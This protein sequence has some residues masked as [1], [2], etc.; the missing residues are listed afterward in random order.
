[1]TIIGCD[2]HPG[3]Q[4]I[5][6]VDTDTGDCGERRLQH[7][8]EAEK[9]Y[10]PIPLLERYGHLRR[11]GASRVAPGP[12]CLHAVAN[13]PAGP[14][15]LNRSLLL[16]RRRPSPGYGRVGSCITVF[17]AC[18]AFTRVT[19]CRLAESPMRPSTPEASAASLPPPPL[20][21]LPGGA[22]QFPGGSTSR[23]GSVPLHGA[24]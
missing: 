19:A 13:A 12:L 15:R 18:S 6:F 3:F 20:R 11:E 22:I 7:V 14:R 8:E 1:M 4:Q 9:F 24:P 5:A 23:C 2:Y 17:G 16:P 10:H 21:L